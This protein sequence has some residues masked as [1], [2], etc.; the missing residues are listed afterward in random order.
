[1]APVVAYRSTEYISSLQK[2][3]YTYIPKVPGHGMPGKPG[4]STPGSGSCPIDALKLGACVDLL[5]GLVHVGAG[6]PVVNKCCPLLK[7]IAEL[8]AAL[9]LC[10]T[11]R[12]KLLNLNI[13]LPLALELFVQCEMTPPAGFTCPSAH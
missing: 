4:S 11:I 9:C 2:A 12:A 6:D 7:G 10:T 1:M 3:P 13:I 5:G 8:E